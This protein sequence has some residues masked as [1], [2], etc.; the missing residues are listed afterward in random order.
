MRGSGWVYMRTVR[1]DGPRASRACC[2]A[3]SLLPCTP[4]CPA[5]HRHVCQTHQHMQSWESW[6]ACTYIYIYILMHAYVRN[7]M[8]QPPRQAL[9]AIACKLLNSVSTLSRSDSLNS[10]VARCASVPS[11]VAAAMPLAVKARGVTR[12]YAVIRGRMSPHRRH[13]AAGTR[14]SHCTACL[15]AGLS[16]LS[17]C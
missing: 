4:C 11:L 16:L 2:W 15:P 9:P 1:D 5:S 3:M 6:Q 8:P 10:S 7:G 17:G 12:L 13:S 14:T